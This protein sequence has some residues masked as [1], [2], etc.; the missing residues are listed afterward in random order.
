MIIKNRFI[1]LGYKILF[2]FEL[3]K[4]QVARFYQ[5][6]PDIIIILGGLKYLFGV[7]LTHCEMIIFMLLLILLFIIV[8]FTLKK[9]GLYDID[10]IVSA[11]RNIVVKEQYMAAKKINNYLRDFDG[12]A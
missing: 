5:F 10:C 12:K 2:Y 1:L 8:G 9:L 4:G 6:L 7:D 3:G 11:E